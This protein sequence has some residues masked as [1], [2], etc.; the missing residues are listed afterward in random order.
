[1]LERFTGPLA[2]IE[3]HASAEELVR[4]LT[5]LYGAGLERTLELVYEAAGERA[6]AVFTA[7]AGDKLVASLMILHGLHPQSVEERVQAAL[8]KVRPYLHSHEGDIEIL[9][10]QDGIVD[11]RLAGSCNG[12]PS[13]LATV[14]LSVET[15]ILEAAP[16]I[17][18][19]RAHGMN[20]GDGGA[21]RHDSDW[22]SLDAHSALA[23]GGS[24]ALE[25]DG[26][27]VLLVGDGRIV[28]AYR[29]Q[30]PRCLHGLSS[31][32]LAWPMLTCRSCDERYDVADAGRAASGADAALEGFAL[33]Y[34][35]RDPRR[36]RLAIPVTA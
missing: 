18:E 13:S 12:C 16:E 36:V 21:T 22:V 14:K 31:A 25:V 8:D 32:P 28:H 34:D 19:V 2:A 9:R 10:V 4:L 11:L 7:L 17:T 5:E 1:M 35:V 15:A 29:N 24:S 20:T 33:S 6:S 27:P 3:A 23:S 30:C 26:A